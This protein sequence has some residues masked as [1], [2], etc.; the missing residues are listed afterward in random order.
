MGEHEA[1][2]SPDVIGTSYHVSLDRG[3]FGER[4]GPYNWYQQPR[5]DDP[6]HHSQSI[7]GCGRALFGATTKTT[8]WSIDGPAG[9]GC[10][11]KPFWFSNNQFAEF[12]NYYCPDRDWY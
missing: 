12:T 5:N 2:I 3:T 10:S 11:G 6:R 8:S 9:D 7:N 4:S 1:R